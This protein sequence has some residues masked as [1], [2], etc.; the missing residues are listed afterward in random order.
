M[1][2]IDLI[3]FR[4]I[5][6][7]NIQQIFEWLGITDYRDGESFIQTR[8]PV[9]KNARKQ[10]SFSYSKKYKCW[11]C[12]SEGCHDKDGVISD[13]MGLTSLIKKVKY[14]HAIQMLQTFL[15]EDGKKL[16][17]QEAQA[18][19]E[20]RKFV[21]QALADN[22]RVKFVLDQTPLC[23]LDRINYLTGRGFLA[24]TIKE[25]DIGSFYKQE[26][27]VIPIHDEYGD[28]VGWSSRTSQPQCVDCRLY[29]NPDL[30][31]ENV[32]R[33]IGSPK[34]R[35][36]KDMPKVQILFNLH[37]A[38]KY[39][40][41]SGTVIITEGQLDVMRL[42][43]AGF[44]NCIALLGTDIHSFQ[45]RMLAR[46]GTFKFVLALDNDDAGK[47]GTETITKKLENLGNVYVAQIPEAKDVGDLSIEEVQSVFS[48][49][50]K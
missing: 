17:E 15:K 39:I 8:C 22:K 14:G 16:N 10:T 46:Y 7:S 29:H 38:K 40:N 48:E 6:N 41:S 49:F 24:S 12:Y 37:R 27:V 1:N 35:H 36:K 31:C 9:H 45:T 11:R 43:E 3:D 13:I 25:F 20:S 4:D 18:I 21:N 19:Q 32:G 5:C 44:K 42:W 50:A 33:K 2:E 34:W 30:V 47:A 26:G 23:E 28:R